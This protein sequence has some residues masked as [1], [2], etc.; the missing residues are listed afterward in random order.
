MRGDITG[1]DQLERALFRAADRKAG[2]GER[3]RK[4]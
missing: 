4:D 2:S 1:S 3:K